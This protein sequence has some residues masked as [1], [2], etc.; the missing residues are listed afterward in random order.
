MTSLYLTAPVYQVLRERYEHWQ[1]MGYPEI[2]AG[3]EPLLD[4]LNSYPGLVTVSSCIG[5][6][7]T[8]KRPKVPL[9]VYMGCTQEGWEYLQRIHAAVTQ[10]LL[11]VHRI[12]EAEC[13]V[14]RGMP[15]SFQQVQYKDF[16]LQLGFKDFALNE[17]EVLTYHRYA[18]IVGG[19]HYGPVRENFLKEFLLCLDRVS[20]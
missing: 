13:A 4:R 17:Q 11:D 7:E 12:Y 16:Q 14:Q 19:T 18:F 10:R 6:R 3:L 20:I 9:Y 2:D 8:P 5:H 15:R 1:R